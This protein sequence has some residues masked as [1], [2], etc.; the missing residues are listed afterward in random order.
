MINKLLTQK[1]IKNTNKWKFSYA[2]DKNISTVLEKML[3]S[4][5][6]ERV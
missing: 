2:K 6:R 3:I 1:T 4:I 5:K